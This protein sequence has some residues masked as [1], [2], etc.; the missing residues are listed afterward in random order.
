MTAFLN[1][2]TRNGDVETH[3]S[4]WENLR[5]NGNIRTNTEIDTEMKSADALDGNVQRHGFEYCHEKTESDY[6][7]PL[8]RARIR[9]QDLGLNSD[10]PTN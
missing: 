8:S 3:K 7:M 10:R 9:T 2:I 1:P 6:C 4:A 5:I